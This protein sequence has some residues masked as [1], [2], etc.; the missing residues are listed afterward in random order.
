M[1]EKFYEEFKKFGNPYTILKI[2]KDVPTKKD[3]K[4]AYKE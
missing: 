3:I 2:E 1:E 4:I